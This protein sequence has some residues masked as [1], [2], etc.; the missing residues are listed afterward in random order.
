MWDTCF[1]L[2]CYG[3]VWGQASWGT[4]A[5]T[6][7]SLA[8]FSGDRQDGE[9]K[10]S[11]ELLAQR[12]LFPGKGL[13]DVFGMGTLRSITALGVEAQGALGVSASGGCPGAASALGHS[14]SLLSLVGH[15]MWSIT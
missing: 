6:G 11:H 9:D 14:V 5:L 1:V 15:G 10:T 12:Y 2:T 8:C 7:S 4:E 3:S 13:W